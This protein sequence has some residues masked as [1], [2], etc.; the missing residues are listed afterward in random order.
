MVETTSWYGGQQS[1][2]MTPT[3]TFPTLEVS[4]RLHLHLIIIVVSCM[5]LLSN[6]L[7]GLE[8]TL[9]GKPLRIPQ[10]LEMPSPKFLGTLHSYAHVI[11]LITMFKI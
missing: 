11:S 1:P 10:F 7:L 8:D 4:Q 6:H 3:G 9:W 2:N 5:Y